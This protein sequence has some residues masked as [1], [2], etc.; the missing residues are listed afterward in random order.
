MCI[1][2]QQGKWDNPSA[3]NANMAALVLKNKITIIIMT[4]HFGT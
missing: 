2:Q 4:F 1:T 3:L